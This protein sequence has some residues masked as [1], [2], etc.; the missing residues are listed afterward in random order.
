MPFIASASVTDFPHKIKQQAVKQRALETFT[1]SYPE[2]KRLIFAFDSTKIE[3]RNFCRPLDYY[4]APNTFEQ[5]NNDYIRTSLKYCVDAIEDCVNKAG[6]NKD[7]ITDIVFVS[8]TGLATPSLDALIINK[9][10]LSPHINRIPVFGLGCGG[11]A[12]GMAKANTLAVANPDAVVLLVCVELCSLTLLKDDYSKSNFIGS[13]LFSDGIAACIVKGDRHADNTGV[14]YVT[15]SSKLYYDTLDIMGWDF[16]NTGFKVLFSKEIPEFISENIKGDVD[17]FL[18]KKGLQLSDIA[19][20]V[21]HPG[22]KKVLEAYDK[23]LALPQC[24]LDNTRAVMRE[25]GNMSSASVLYVL[26]RFM[27]KGFAPGYALMLAM[28]PGFSSEMVLLEVKG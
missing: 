26:E 19:N 5:R 20:F 13:S 12:S 7:N 21:F 11:G 28:G 27:S 1:D 4:T 6:I 10:R 3:T 23:A 8:T 15:A 25:C 16:L 2:A 14:R 17:D 18:Q 24:A 22:G 9:M